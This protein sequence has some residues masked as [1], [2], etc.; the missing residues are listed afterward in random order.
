MFELLRNLVSVSACGWDQSPPSPNNT[1]PSI[2]HTDTRT[3]ITVAH[4]RQLGS[5]Y[6]FQSPWQRPAS[7]LTNVC[8]P[9]LYFNFL[10]SANQQQHFSF[11]MCDSERQAWIQPVVI[12]FPTPKQLNLK[13]AKTYIS[14]CALSGPALCMELFK[15]RSVHRPRLF[16]RHCGYST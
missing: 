13:I 11:E 4:R 14:L 15:L 6:T 1:S 5:R 3:H 8:L 12:S 10:L 7:W 16:C 9:G 2:P